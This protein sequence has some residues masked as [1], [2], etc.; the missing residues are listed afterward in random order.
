MDIVFSLWWSLCHLVDQCKLFV[1]IRVCSLCNVCSCMQFP[2]EKGDNSVTQRKYYIYYIV[3]ILYIYITCWCVLQRNTEL[4][5][6][7]AEIQEELDRINSLATK[8]IQEKEV[9][10]S[11]AAKAS[12]L[13]N[14]MIN[15]VKQLR[16]LSK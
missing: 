5:N 2:S 4:I 10:V 16:R 14:N 15:I 7:S 3:V 12:S 13:L 6:K 9:L 11:D 1:S 8:M